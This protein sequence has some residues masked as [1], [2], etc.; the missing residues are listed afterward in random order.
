MTREEFNESRFAY[1][2]KFS[3]KNEFGDNDVF[4]LQTVDF[5]TGSIRDILGR[6]HKIEDIELI[7]H[8]QQNRNQHVK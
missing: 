7:I 3:N 1:L 6:L 4:C 8:K 5:G 2:D